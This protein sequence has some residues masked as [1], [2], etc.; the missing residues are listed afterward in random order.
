VEWQEKG[1]LGGQNL[2][3][4]FKPNQPTNYKTKQ[5][6]NNKKKSGRIVECPL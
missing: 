2:G 4:I 3:L 6:Q 1:E 5:K